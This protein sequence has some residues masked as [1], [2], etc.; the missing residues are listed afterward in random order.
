MLGA[1]WMMLT[2]PLIAKVVL[3]WHIRTTRIAQ[4]HALDRQIYRLYY[5]VALA[6]RGK[7]RML[8]DHAHAKLSSGLPRFRSLS[9]QRCDLRGHNHRLSGSPASSVVSICG[10]LRKGRTIGW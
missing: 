2:A 3:R 1:L 6:K 10:S 5:V 8:I 4:A 7:K 9:V